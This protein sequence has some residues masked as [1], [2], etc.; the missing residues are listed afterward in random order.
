MFPLSSGNDVPGTFEDGIVVQNN[1]SAALIVRNADN[2]V[3]GRLVA[4]GG[5]YVVGTV[6]DHPMN[7]GTNNQNRVTI[8]SDGA[9]GIG[10]DD[11]DPLAVFLQPARDPHGQEQRDGDCACVE[12][13]ALPRSVVA[14]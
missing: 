14:Q 10:T 8:T 3:E 9:V 12:V 4:T 11:P 1:G 6:T 7:L 2:D 13:A 5:D